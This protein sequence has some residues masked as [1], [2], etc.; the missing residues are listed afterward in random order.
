MTPQMVTT[1]NACSV[2]GRRPVE[3]SVAERAVDEE[4]RAALSDSI[5]A[6]SSQMAQYSNEP[7]TKQ[8]PKSRCKSSTAPDSGYSSQ[9]SSPN[10][11]SQGTLA[12]KESIEY[13]SR[14]RFPRKPKKLRIYDKPI[15]QPTQTRF[16][17]LKVL[18]GRTLHEF[19]AKKKVTFTA[20]QMRLSVLGED[21]ASAKP[22]II[23]ACEKA[24]LKTVKQFFGQT[25]IK[26]E[27]Q[28]NTGEWPAF[29]L[30]I[31][32]RA[33]RLLT[34]D[35]DIEVFAHDRDYIKGL[36]ARSACGM[37]IKAAQNGGNQ[38]LWL[39]AGHILPGDSM[40]GALENELEIK[41]VKEDGLDTDDSQAESY[42]AQ[43]SNLEPPD[44]PHLDHPFSDS[45][46]EEFEIEFGYGS[47]SPSNDS[48][49]QGREEQS[50]EHNPSYLMNIGRTVA[51][52]GQ[53]KP[54]ML[55]NIGRIVAHSSQS[56]PSMEE[57]CNRD[58]ALIELNEA[59]RDIGNCLIDGRG[60]STPFPLQLTQVVEQKIL[61]IDGE[62]PVGVIRTSPSPSWGV[63]SRA[64]SFIMISPGN[65]FTETYTLTL[66]P[67][68]GLKA[69]DSGS[70]VFDCQ[71]YKVYGHVV[72]VDLFGEGIVVPMHA[73]LTDIERKFNA[74]AVWLRD[75]LG[76]PGETELVP[77]HL[78]DITPERIAPIGPDLFT[79]IRR[80]S[81]IYSAYAPEEISPQARVLRDL[82][83]P[84]Q[85]RS[86]KRKG[87]FV[88]SAY[89]SHRGSQTHRHFFSTRR[90][91]FPNA[92]S[93]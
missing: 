35:I 46:E 47:M 42:A 31:C 70:W 39:T 76:R 2:V 23:I 27:L 53:S 48:A 15:D 84:G 54:S 57:D 41:S 93:R 87:S 63:L 68:S 24:T 14:R 18:F 25:D 56:K 83:S 4:W 88:D 45:N 11:P 65:A 33:L 92:S 7:P 38:A 22:W 16:L 12:G 62:R 49:S 91:R 80:E 86:L 5:A 21:E 66:G 81:S 26:E 82:D 55:T 90:P 74:T 85:S 13:P 43:E 29:E 89:S 1:S 50:G 77:Q 34:A 36:F 44:R 32:D 73:I 59:Q 75:L 64:W 37:A 79:P 30:I 28:A 78:R 67:K 8:N 19:L 9:V 72:A 71:N 10:N 17:D 6:A 51:H 3:D 52:S 58:W 60:D 61:Q 69:G 20:I 40:L